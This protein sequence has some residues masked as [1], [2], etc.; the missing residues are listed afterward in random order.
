MLKRISLLAFTLPMFCS[1]SVLADDALSLKQTL[2]NIDGLKANFQ[3]TVTDIN[4]KTIQQ[5]SGNFALA[6]PNKFYWH[7][8]QP[9]ESLIV[10]DGTDVWIYNPFAEEVSV[11]DFNQAISAS[12][13]ALLVHRDEQTWANYDVNLTGHCYQIT[14]KEIGAGVP[15]VE[16]CF[17]QKQLSSMK[18]EDQQGNI[19]EFSLS[20][21]SSL[22][23]DDTQLFQ[24]TVPEGVDIDDQRL[25]AMN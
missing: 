3:Q 9:D 15:N 21:Q 22:D 4:G 13:I 6:V 25:K 10:A 5:G 16:V 23:K 12:P 19:S 8:T 1:L 11:M 2:V 24:F 14:A 18:L 20:Q 7:L 17:N